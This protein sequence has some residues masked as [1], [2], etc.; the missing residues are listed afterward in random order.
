MKLYSNLVLL[1]SLLLGLI[2]SALLAKT[3]YD[4]E[5]K[6]IIIEFHKSVDDQIA[7]IEREVTFNL[8]ALYAIKG[9]FDNS[10]NVTP[11]EFK[12]ITTQILSRHRNIQALEWIP[13]VSQEQ[14]TIFEERR[15]QQYP[16]FQ[17]IERKQQG[18]MVPAAVRDE[19]FPVYYVEPLSGNEAAFGFDLASNSKRLQAL[20]LA[21][22]SGN[23]VATA[24]ITLVQESQS[25]KGF[26][27][28]LPIYDG[29]P[30]TV[31]Q[32]QQQLSGFAL[33]VFKIGD[34]IDS[35]N[36]HQSLRGINFALMDENTSPVEVLYGST[37]SDNKSDMSYKRLLQPIGGRQWSIVASPS[38]QYIA[39]QRSSTPFFIF[40]LAVVFIIFGAAY[41][42]LL[43]RHST[44]IERA[45]L[46]RTIQLNEANTELERITLLDGLTGV[47][48]RRHFDS[49][50]EQE[51]ARAKRDKHPITLIMI[52][53]DYFKPFNDHY[54]HLAGDNCLK[55]VA[56][57]I[58]FTVK[59]TTDLVARYGGEEF[60]IILPNI[61]DGYIVAERC[62]Q[63]IEKA[64]IP[65]HYSSVTN[66]ITI[67]VGISSIIPQNNM[68]IKDLDKTAD[69]ALYRAKDTG[70][71]KT[72][73]S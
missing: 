64:G 18:Q 1:L 69:Q 66:H 34:V 54:G 12:A 23:L 13:K 19:Y 16:E 48:N 50:L 33:G 58:D 28:F 25:Q 29:L 46:E 8:E 59:R 62:R 41:V 2:F 57:T 15:Q 31:T 53:I 52:D 44:S 47:A 7:S 68:K 35:S 6:A 20:N 43:S 51:W 70:R 14:R 45:V 49:Y 40:L 60:A 37:S 21:R 39:E 22:Q 72:I 73:T 61:D 9:L 11:D 42:F 67:S 36:L 71:N 24:S 65:H 30:V 56:Q 38:N 63:N 5:T 26:L 10:D 17:I 32:R 27:A 55:I 4:I 3:F